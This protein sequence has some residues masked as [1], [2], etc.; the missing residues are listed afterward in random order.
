M[1]TQEYLINLEVSLFSNPIL[2]ETSACRRVKSLLCA[3]TMWV[4][5]SVTSGQHCWPQSCLLLT[6]PYFAVFSGISPDSHQCNWWADCASLQFT[7]ESC[8]KLYTEFLLNSFVRRVR[9]VQY[10]RNRIWPPSVMDLGWLNWLWKSI[11]FIPWQENF[12]S[13]YLAFGA[14]LKEGLPLQGLRV[15][16]NYKFEILQGFWPKV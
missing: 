6:S 8:R 10:G 9:F 1:D 16:K 11:S 5:A 2:E 13:W 15:E 4:L 3:F 12:S 7:C 14:F